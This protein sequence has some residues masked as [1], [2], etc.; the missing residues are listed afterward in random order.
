MINSVQ[1][2]YSTS[3]RITA[4]GN[5]NGSG[6]EVINNTIKTNFKIIILSIEMNMR[7]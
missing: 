5:W 6:E 4:K 1:V 2:V 7:K 3:Q